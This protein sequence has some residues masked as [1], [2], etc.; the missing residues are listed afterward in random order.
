MG[1]VMIVM[2][3]REAKSTVCYARTSLLKGDKQTMMTIDDFNNLIHWIAGRDKIMTSY[4]NIIMK[5]SNM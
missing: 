5:Q 4:C 3:F 2:I 1:G